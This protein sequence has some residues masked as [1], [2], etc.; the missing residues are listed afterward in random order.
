MRRNIIEI[1]EEKCTGC[2]LCIRD[3]AEGA[4][5]LVDGKARLIRDSYC[6]GL[7]ACLGACP[8]GALTVIQR[9]APAFD[10]E[11]A[12]EALR[13]RTADATP[14]SG[15]CPG[16]RPTGMPEQPFPKGLTPLQTSPAANWP[17]QLRLVPADAPFLQRARLL[18]AA[19]CTAFAQPELLARHLSGRA[20]LIACPKLDDTSSYVE[21]LAQIFR[22]RHIQDI[23]VLHMAVPCCTGL[24]ALVD[25]AL[26][27]SGKN[28]PLTNEKV[29]LR[30]A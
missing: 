20:L 27:T 9:E 16:A 7:G 26:R 3:C 28:I 19:D 29:P 8:E 17:I 23:L 12:M 11:A 6:D 4:L 24:A 30:G 25:A 2:G 5:A 1:D 13:H 14:G 21:K 10:E 15:L 22:T 18:I